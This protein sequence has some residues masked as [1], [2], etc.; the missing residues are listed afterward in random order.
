MTF[1]GIALLTAGGTIV[2]AVFAIVAAWYARKAFREQ[3]KEVSDQAKML[4]VQSDQLTEDRKVNAEQIRVLILQAEDLR[5]S[6]RERERLRKAAERAQAD[7]ISFRLTATR[8]PNIAEE[9]SGR[10]FVVAPGET[11]HMAIVSNGSR[12]PIKNV[13]CSLGDAPDTDLFPKPHSDLAVIAGR[14]GAADAPARG[15][16]PLV[17]MFP[18]SRVLQILPEE[19]YGFVFE[20]NS[21]HDLSFSHVTTRFTDDVGLRWQI[22][23][24]QHLER[25]PN[26]E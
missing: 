21:H 11:V 25:L 10:N 1:F 14:L 6:V 23:R 24:S 4:E 26:S 9:D 2:L 7:E 16:P 17:D 12:R 5:E 19:E 3:S 15:H 8:F 18:R 13:E 20:L 22:D